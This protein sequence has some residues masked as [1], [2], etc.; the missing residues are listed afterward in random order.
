MRLGSFQLNQ[1]QR[2]VFVVITALYLMACGS[3]DKKPAATPAKATPPPAKAEVFIVTPQLSAQEIE[4]PGSLVPFEET[5]MRPEISGKVRAIYFREGSTVAKG[6]LLVKLD[7]ADLQAQL[8]KL[9]V[10]LA[11]A[12]KTEER[13]AALLKINGISQQ[14]YD[15][16]L[17]AV[18]NLNADIGILKTSIDKTNIRAPYSGTLGF[19]NI[20]LGAYISPLTNITTLRQLY[21]LKLVFDI[22]ERYGAKMQAGQLVRFTIDGQATTHAATIIANESR[23]NADTRTLS[24]KAQVQGAQNGLIAGGFAKVLFTLDRN[25]TALMVPTQ[26]IIPQARNKKIMALRNGLATLETVNTGIRDS[27]RVEITNGLKA[28]DTILVSGL[29]SIKPGSMVQ[30]GKIIN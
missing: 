9:Q 5:E 14:D 7:D 12:Q 22:P 19:R 17:L 23:I 1:N 10:Q 26:A 4:L 15:L 11:I 25:N 21:P 24:V 3:S 28:G 29:L 20:S 8:K 16:S 2:V 30:V 6:S 18:N 27:G 13:Q